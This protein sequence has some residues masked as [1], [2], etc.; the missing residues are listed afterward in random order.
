MAYP[1]VRARTETALTT[2]GT[3]ITINFGTNNA[4]DLC[5]A[6]IGLSDTAQAITTTESFTN[7]T[8]AS[9]TFHIIYKILAGTEG[10]STTVTVPSST[11]AAVLAYTINTGTFLTT[12]APQFSTVATG[13]DQS[14]NPAS[15]TPTG[16]A[17][18]YFW[19]AAFRQNGE[20]A[21]DDTWVTAV[22]TTPGTFTN[23]IQKTSGTVSTATTNGSIAS[24][25]YT[26]TASSMDPGAFTV[27]QNLAWRA[28]T[29]AVHPANATIAA[30]FAANAVIKGTVTPTGWKADAT[31]KRTQSATFFIGNNDGTGGA[32][33]AI[34]STTY[35]FTDKKADAVILA[36]SGTKT[37]TANAVIAKTWTPT[38]TANAVIA[39]TWTPTFTANAVIR[40][41]FEPAGWATDA[42]KLKTQTVL[43]VTGGTGGNGGL[44]PLLLAS[45]SDAAGINTLDAV[46]AASVAT[47]GGTLT[48][49]AVLKATSA[50]QA[51]TANA[52]LLADSGTLT[53]T[54]A[55]TVL[56]DQSGSLTANAVILKTTATALTADAAILKTAA[57][58]L[59][60]D[61][62]ITRT[63]TPT[64][65]LSD[66]VIR[67]EQAGSFAANAVVSKSQTGSLAVNAVTR[68][69]VTGSLTS[70]AIR[71]RTFY[72][73][74]GPDPR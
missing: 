58:N 43:G 21:D 38:F 69:A 10:T 51:F 72:F 11:K 36:G 16:G 33:I 60:A 42:I 48:A 37:F 46:I 30:S 8:N 3:T 2:A 71:L 73:G 53:F 24:A 67:R 27:A 47:V 44:I 35:T 18:D 64:G 25:E 1:T 66:A 74:S 26:S 20:E 19:I 6:F 57:G 45:L 28:Y 7:L 40:K 52:V 56:K 39:K 9:G 29:V 65:Y 49:D 59:T 34:A 4:G 32:V 54:A 23:L 12:Q 63:F 50:T 70:D 13:T 22:P 41:T 68:K 17:K 15:L 31:Q 5:I 62:V 55:T 14:P 61:A